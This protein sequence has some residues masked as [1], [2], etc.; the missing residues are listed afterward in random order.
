MTAVTCLVGL[1]S[2]KEV[3]LPERLDVFAKLD[4]CFPSERVTTEP[5][6]LLLYIYCQLPPD[7][8]RF[9]YSTFIAS[10]HL[11]WTDLYTLSLPRCVIMYEINSG[12]LTPLK[13]L[14]HFISLRGFTAHSGLN[15]HTSKRFL[16]SMSPSNTWWRYSYLAVATRARGSWKV[17]LISIVCMWPW[18]TLNYAGALPY[19]LIRI[20]EGWSRIVVAMNFKSSTWKLLMKCITLQLLNLQRSCHCNPSAC[21]WR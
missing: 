19:K 15:M 18:L 9:V 11:T 13:I 8:D 12:I 3:G 1:T 2:N 21:V 16:P 20:N 10:C 4:Q 17:C 5:Q 14:G 6:S 7:M